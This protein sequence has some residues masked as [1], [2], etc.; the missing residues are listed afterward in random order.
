MERLQ[1]MYS[2]MLLSKLKANFP[3]PCE[4]SEQSLAIPHTQQ[5]HFE[6]VINTHL[7]QGLIEQVQPSHY[8]LT[9]K[10][11]GMFGDSE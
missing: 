10:A 11:L 6:D 5:D 8:T 4:L 3:Q 1:N 9:N 7:S 2:I